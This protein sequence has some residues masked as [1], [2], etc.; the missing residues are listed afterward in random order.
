M[1]DT[2]TTVKRSVQAL[3]IL[4]GPQPGSGGGQT[5]TEDPLVSSLLGGPSPASA[6]AVHHGFTCDATKVMPII[7]VRFKSANFLD[8]DLCT[9]ARRTG[10]FANFNGFIP[11]PDPVTAMRFALGA[12][13]CWWRLLWPDRQDLFAAPVDLSSLGE[14][15]LRQAIM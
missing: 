4:A 3:K 7:G 10:N 6:G 1:G 2:D 12:I 8:A 13:M 14:Q 9:E 11:L 15:H 5:L